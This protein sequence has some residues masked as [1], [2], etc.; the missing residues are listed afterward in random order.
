AV[1][2]STTVAPARSA[3]SGERTTIVP[4][5]WNVTVAPPCRLACPR[6]SRSVPGPASSRD[7]TDTGSAARDAAADRTRSAAAVTCVDADRAFM[8]ASI[9]GALSSG[10]GIGEPPGGMGGA[11][12]PPGFSV[13]RRRARQLV[14]G[15][16]GFLPDARVLV[17]QRGAQERDGGRA[18]GPAESP[19]RPGPHSGVG[20][21][22][23][24]R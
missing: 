12:S 3:G 10:C 2:P 1:H 15:L 23:R 14:E 20:V 21:A 4:A 19:Q 16:T 24:G 18:A 17:L 11:R 13:P 6:A 8:G 5:T 9:R 22:E 7:V